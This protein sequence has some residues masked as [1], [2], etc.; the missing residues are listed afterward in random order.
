MISAL[1]YCIA[2]SVTPTCTRL[3]KGQK[4]GIVGIGGLGHMGIKLAHALGAHVVA[5]TTSESKR[6]DALNLGADE[7]ERRQISL[8]HRHG[9]PSSNRP[10]QPSCSLASWVPETG[11]A[12]AISLSSNFCQILKSWQSRAGENIIVTLVKV[13]KFS[14]RNAWLCSLARTQFLHA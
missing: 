9:F 5:F 2:A 11:V 14:R 6:K 4:V 13:E 7:V 8:R 3:G 10:E 1:K 12:T